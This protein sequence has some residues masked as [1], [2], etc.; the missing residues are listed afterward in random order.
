MGC[1]TPVKGLAKR[2][3]LIAP[4]ESGI[5]VEELKYQLRQTQEEVQRLQKLFSEQTGRCEQLLQD[6]QS[7]EIE[8]ARLHQERK[9][10]ET[11]DT[12]HLRRAYE[13]WQTEAHEEFK[14]Q[15]DGERAKT[16]QLESQYNRLREKKQLADQLGSLTS[17]N[18]CPQVD[19]KEVSQ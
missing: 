3:S 10:L 15:L 8:I 17:E 16:S 9:W 19:R 6:K 7:K 4:S 12:E 1:S 2:R 14:R 13:L 11:R 18:A 5:Q